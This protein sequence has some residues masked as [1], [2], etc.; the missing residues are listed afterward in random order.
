[1]TK[2]NL[3]SAT[4]S[5]KFGHSGQYPEH[6]TGV[7][8]Y[9]EARVGAR[10]KEMPF[11]GL[12]PLLTV[13]EQGVTRRDVD[14]AEAMSFA[15]HGRD[16]FNR[17]RW[18]YILEAHNGR[19]P[20]R[21]KAVAEG[22][23]VP[24]NNVMFTVENTDPDCFWLTNHLE[25]FLTHV[26]HASLVAT[27]SREAKKIIAKYL[28][29]TAESRAALPFMLHDFGYRG[30][31][32]HEAGATGGAAH[33]INFLGSDTVPAVELLVEEYG[34]DAQEGLRYSDPK[35][36]EGIACSVVATEHSVM[37]ALGKAGE[38]QQVQRL[39]DDNPEG[40]ISCVIDSYNMYKFVEMCGTHFKPQIMAREGKFVF[41]PDSLSDEHRSKGELNVFLLNELG[42]YFG[43]TVNAKGFKV[44]NAKV[45]LIDGDGNKLPDIEETLEEMQLNGWSAENIV[46]GMGGGLHQAGLDRDTQ[47]SAFKSS[48]Q[49]RGVDTPWLKVQK[50]P[51]DRTKKSKAGRLVLTKALESGAFI[52]VQE[53]KSALEVNSECDGLAT[54]NYLQTVFENGEVV[55][56]HSLAEV[57]ARAEL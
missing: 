15:I 17:A 3:A 36:Y 5:Y 20:V 38:R 22:T 54:R 33:L 32:N 30:A 9:F 49:Q 53:G 46:F 7:Y 29:N 42:R 26:W 39:L 51:L 48:A 21:I 35:L 44:L 52:T 40:I 28:D 37:T 56:R 18:D 11:F 50:N 34:E 14:R 16:V 27:V 8:S 13:L 2:I 25:S 43:Y 6:T 45:G 57:R 47:R 1:M 12:Q 31:V 4:D 19:L 24:I 55:L 41:R 10:F 23:V